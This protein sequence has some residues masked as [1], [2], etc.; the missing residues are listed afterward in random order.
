P[1]RGPATAR[2]AGRGPKRSSEDESATW[3][4]PPVIRGWMFSWGVA[5]DSLN[6]STRGDLR[7]EGDGQPYPLEVGIARPRRPP[8]VEWSGSRHLQR[9]L[10]RCRYD[11]RLRGRAAR[12]VAPVPS[13]RSAD[14]ERGGSFAG[15]LSRLARPGTRDG[16]SRLADAVSDQST[17]QGL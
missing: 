12:S 11:H 1:R 7:K 13:P 5:G 17:L 14:A 8:A 6:I 9:C 4:G 3:R 2:Q 16:T 10:R 15:R